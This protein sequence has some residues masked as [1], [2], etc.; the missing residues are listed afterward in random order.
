M[1]IVGEK[2]ASLPPGLESL[3]CELHR[4]LSS[5]QP[6]RAVTLGPLDEEQRTAL[7]DFFGH[8]VL[9]DAVT[10]ARLDEVERTLLAATGLTVRVAVGPIGDR[11]AEQRRRESERDVLWDWLF[12]HEVVRAQPALMV[13][14]ESAKRSGLIAGSGPKR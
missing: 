12:G 3:W 4:R 5:G 13:W 6:V 10:K 7:A 1:D 9:P 14:A 11:R 2:V 8:E